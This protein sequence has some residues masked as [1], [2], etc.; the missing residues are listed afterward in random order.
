MNR[1][2]SRIYFLIILFTYLFLITFA[3]KQRIK[4][5]M[6]ITN[7]PQSFAK[8]VWEKYRNDLNNYFIE[9]TK[10][11]EELNNYVLDIF[12][13]PYI[14]PG[15]DNKNALLDYMKDMAN[16]LPKGEYDMIILDERLLFSEMGMMESKKVKQNLKYRY[17]S[18]EL[19]H[20]LSKYIDR[21][22]LEFH[23][24]KILSGGMYNNKII[25]IPY[26]FDFD[27]MYFHKEDPNTQL[28]NDIQELV[29]N[30]ESYSWNDLI[31]EMEKKSLLYR[32]SLFDDND[33]LNFVVEY[34]SSLYNISLENDSDYMK[35]FYNE[36]STEYYKNFG[37]FVQHCSNDGNAINQINTSVDNLFFNFMQ[38]NL[39][40]FTAKASNAFPIE[41]LKSEYIVTLPPKNKSVTTHKYLVAN[42]FSKIKPDVLAKVAL[43]LTSKEAQLLREKTF[44]TIPTFDFTK[45]NNDSEI[46]SYCQKRPFIC[47]SMEKMDKIY[48]RDFFNS[49]YMVPFFDIECFIPD[50]FKTFFRF[51]KVEPI[52]TIMLNMNEFIT[53]DLKIYGTLSVIVTSLIVTFFIF[54]ICMTYKLK[55]HPYIKV[56]SPLFCILIVIGC[57]LNLFKLLKFIPPYSLGK[58]KFFLIHE[59]LGTNLIFVP[60]FAVTYRIYHIFKTKTLISNA[61]SNKCLFINVLIAINVAVIYNLVIVFTCNFYYESVGSI[62]DGRIP[63]GYYS[64]IDILKKLYQIY[65]SVIVK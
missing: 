1:R 64:N 26:E 7:M 20:D 31:S 39:T 56:I 30:M 49:K 46:Q 50:K 43:I 4:L 40:I 35:L 28:Y 9:K 6:K 10:D 51:E 60:M 24:P 47:D 62:D 25:G 19:F 14:V 44:A 34:T 21:K 29:D 59:A 53:T 13:Y 61:F 2:I 54:V 11:N 8:D 15:N 27:V 55:E 16:G 58:I 23:D 36:S 38:G 37:V 5:C 57:I 45:R 32:I 52:K 18:L 33:V 48:I 22:D 42:K 63:V 41:M 3:E 17:P 65:L 12:Y